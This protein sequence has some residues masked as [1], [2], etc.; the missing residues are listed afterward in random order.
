MGSGRLRRRKR[1]ATAPPPPQPRPNP[2]ETGNEPLGASDSSVGAATTSLK[3]CEASKPPRATPRTAKLREIFGE[4]GSADSRDEPRRLRP[5]RGWGPEEVSPSQ[6]R[7][8]CSFCRKIDPTDRTPLQKIS[9]FLS[10]ASQPPGQ[11]GRGTSFP[12]QRFPR[13]RTPGRTVAVRHGK[14]RRRHRPTLP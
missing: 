1:R 8:A 10:P 4:G 9:I 7:F 6:G 13:K 14:I 3:C 11:P 12:R 2:I 5:A